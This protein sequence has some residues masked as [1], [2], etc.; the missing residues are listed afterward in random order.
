MS[1]SGV[2]PLIRKKKKK[3]KG[4][5]EEEEE[6]KKKRFTAEFIGRAMHLLHDFD[7]LHGWTLLEPA[8]VF[9]LRGPQHTHQKVNSTQRKR[10]RRRRR[11]RRRRKWGGKGGLE[12]RQKRKKKHTHTQKGAA[13]ENN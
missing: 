2:N 7:L 9:N 6:E 11:S 1:S 12:R 3:T 10:R 5:E 8:Q 13:L 4:E